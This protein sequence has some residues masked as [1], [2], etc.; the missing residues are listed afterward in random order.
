LEWSQLDI[1]APTLL[2]VEQL[3]LVRNNCRKICSQF[4]ISKDHW[5]NLRVIN[6]EQNGI[7]SWDE[8]VGF[9]VLN[10]LQKII[11]NKNLMKEIYR[12]PGFKNLFYLSVEDNL[13]NEWSTLD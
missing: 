8:I 13:I 12:K 11:V 5:K 6:L 7:E 3:Y 2:Y 10:D 1:L 4:E 9:R